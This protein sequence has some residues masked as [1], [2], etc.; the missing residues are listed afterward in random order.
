MFDISWWWWWWLVEGNMN[1]FFSVWFL[2]NHQTL[3]NDFVT[4]ESN[5]IELKRNFSL[6]VL[7]LLVS[8]YI[9]FRRRDVSFFFILL[10]RD[11]WWWLFGLSFV[12]L[13]C[14]CSSSS[15]WL[16]IE[17]SLV[18]GSISFVDCWLSNVS[19]LVRCVRLRVP[20]SRMIQLW[21]SVYYSKWL[22]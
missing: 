2:S 1:I 13:V 20:F 5:Q 6:P 3:S 7:E 11:R 12:V 15:E 4:C 21:V 17:L 10:Y 19:I 16:L 22:N 8:F 18:L 9:V 14:C